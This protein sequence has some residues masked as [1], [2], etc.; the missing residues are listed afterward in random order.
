MTF[1]WLFFIWFHLSCATSGQQTENKHTELD[2]QDPWEKN[3][4]FAISVVLIC[5][6]LCGRC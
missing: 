3:C 1:F 5:G 4:I 2:H 6:Y